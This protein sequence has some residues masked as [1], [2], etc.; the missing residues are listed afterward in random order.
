MLPSFLNG[1]RRFTAVEANQS[2]YVTKVRWVVEAANARIKQFKLLANVVANSSLRNLESYISIVCS[3][4]NRYNPPIKNDHCSD[5]ILIEK[6]NSLSKEK[7]TFERVGF[8]NN[9][10]YFVV[11]L[12]L[13]LQFLE[14]QGL[15]QNSSKWEIIDHVEILDQF[16]ILSED[17]I[18]KN[19]TL[20]ASL[21]Q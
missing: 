9:Y 15:K 13:P 12:Q 2:R 20:G 5:G 3:L 4:I 18:I 10:Q 14:Q 17:D 16:P 8:F 6:M 21:S 11:F 19:I 7:K 1:R